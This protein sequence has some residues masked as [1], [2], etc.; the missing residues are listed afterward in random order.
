M[1][2]VLALH[3]LKEFEKQDRLCGVMALA[4]KLVD[5][6]ALPASS[7]SVGSDY[8]VREVPRMS[9]F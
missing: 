5:N 9:L 1:S 8:V 7:S 2:H 3:L 4:F 6:I